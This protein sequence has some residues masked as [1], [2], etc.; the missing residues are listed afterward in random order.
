M[1][2]GRD[3]IH[4]IK[5]PLLS[6]KSTWGMNEQ[7][8]YAFLVAREA[9]K[10]EIRDAVEALYKVKVRSV[11]TQVRKGKFRRMKFGLTRE[12]TTKKAVV[13]LEEG[14]KIELF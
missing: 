8:R 13:R 9:S 3:P 4:V 7:G 6:E 11:N 14:S 10:D 1:A 12:E 2:S 5:Q